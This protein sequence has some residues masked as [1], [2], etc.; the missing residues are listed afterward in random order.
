MHCRSGLRS[1][2]RILQGRLELRQQMGFHTYEAARKGRLTKFVKLAIQGVLQGDVSKVRWH[3][4]SIVQGEI[5]R[6]DRPQRGRSLAELELEPGERP[7][8]RLFLVHEEADLYE[9]IDDA[10]AGDRDDCSR[11]PKRRMQDRAPVAIDE[12]VGGVRLHTPAL[13]S[14]RHRRQQVGEVGCNP[15]RQLVPLAGAEGA[16]VS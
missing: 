2:R 1:Y 3:A 7:I 10:L 16:L 5:S 4:R 14:A 15:R 13:L 12:R 9:P 11:A 6:I 8:P